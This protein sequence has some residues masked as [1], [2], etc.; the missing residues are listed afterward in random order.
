MGL[1]AVI[2]ASFM[3]APDVAAPPSVE[4][5][6]GTN[7]GSKVVPPKSIKVLRTRSGKVQT[8]EFR[9]YVAIVM[10]SGEWP[11]WMPS[12]ALEAGAVATKQY[13]WYY[14]LRGNHRRGYRKAGVCYDVRDDTMDQLYRPERAEPT[15]KQFEAIDDT[16]GLTLRKN[17]RFF[18]TGYRAGERRRC[19]ADADGWHLFARSVVTCARQRDWSRERIQ[20]AYYGRGVEFVWAPG[21]RGPEVTAPRIKLTRRSSLYAAFAKVSWHSQGGDAS[22][23]TRYRLEHRIGSG[24]WKRVRLARRT[25]TSARVDLRMDKA[26]R[27]R[28]RAKERDGDR[29][30]WSTSD[31][32]RVQLRGPKRGAE[33]GQSVV[34]ADRHDDR[35][36]LRFDG[37]SVAL[38]APVGPKMGRAEIKIDGKVVARVDLERS[39]RHVKKLVWARNW[40]R[41]RVRRVVVQPAR[42]RDRLQVDGFIVL[43]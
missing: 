5:A 29:G 2:V 21:W 40:G 27:F 9:R 31:R 43:R 24:D 19:A 12:A 34:V 30:H 25:A 11:T 20:E 39:E 3:T 28:V 4:A 16:W 14:A 15:H 10:A 42:K 41:E 13:A 32:A 1:S 23:G 36:R 6:C 7:H 26:H 35:A 17:G 22:R 37:R 8:V 33:F 38:V 18:L